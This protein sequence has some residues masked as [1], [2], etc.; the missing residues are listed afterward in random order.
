MIFIGQEDMSLKERICFL[1]E[2]GRNRI[3]SLLDPVDVRNFFQRSGYAIALSIVKYFCS[4]KYEN[5]G[6]GSQMAML[7]NSYTMDCPH[8]RGL[9]CVQV[10]KHGIVILNHL[11]QCRSCILR[12]ISCL[13]C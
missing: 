13:S 8:V 4:L 1:W 9:S 12:D 7:S 10:D 2:K 3:E 6:V 11:H 5:E